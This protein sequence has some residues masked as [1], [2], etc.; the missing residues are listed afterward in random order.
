[1]KSVTAICTAALLVGA[2][3]SSLAATTDSRIQELEN[4]IQ[5]LS[6]QVQELKDSARQQEDAVKAQ[7]ESVKLQQAEVQTQQAE[8]KKQQSAAAKP[9]IANGRLSVSSAD[10]NFSAAI[11]TLLQVDAGTYLQQGS[12]VTL[13]AAY[14]PDLSSGANLRRVFL[15]LQ[16]KVF[17]DWSYYFLYD[18]GG[19]S[20]ETQGHI[21]YAYLEYDG[22]APWAV[23][24][25]AYTPPLNLEDQ[26]SSADLMFLERNSP[27]NIQRNI[28]G[29]EGRDAI[30]VIYAGER[31]FG[32]LS[33]TGNKVQ[34]GSKA[35][36]P[37]GATATSNYD[38]Q[39]AVVGRLSYLPISSDD[40]HWIVGVNGLH[41]FKLPD[42]VPNGAA[43]LATTPGAPAKSSYA[44]GDLPEISI[45]SNGIQLITT[46]ALPADHV[47]S[48]GVETAANYRNFYGQAG[49]YAYDINRSPMAYNVYSAP[50]VYAP[51][52]VQPG[53]NAFSGWY[54]QG[55]W[56]L[57]GESR[58]YSPATASFTTP[59]VAKPFSLKDGGWGAFEVVA[60]YSDVDLND[61]ANDS[62]MVI[63][64]WTPTSRSYTYY[65]T[66]RGGEQRIFSF[67]INWYLNAVVRTSLAYLYIDVSRLQA[68]GTV[69][70][71]GTPTLPMLNA[72]QRLSTVALR[73]QLSL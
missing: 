59:K 60:R 70:T 72:G 57:T 46:G 21:L 40:A 41:V 37:A 26:T 4:Q 28:A 12:A 7:Q 62:S 5:A 8:F 69:T 68:P 56:I 30:S 36:A 25:G 39:L 23:R 29:A 31:M 2:S 38:E 71:S 51:T 53:N 43:T 49:Y 1:M 14:G 10:G 58:I 67:G 55:S 52:I 34:D 33:F 16:G 64:N 44:L 32:A 42:L 35:L 65:N 18:F 54:V 3:S 17:G 19:P 24:V 9:S 61:R 27:S 48:W 50:G 11:R 20:T 15:G 45:D 22:L 63:T 6:K 66:V 13:P 47:T 73:T